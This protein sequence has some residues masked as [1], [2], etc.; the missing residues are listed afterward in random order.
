MRPAEAAVLYQVVDLGTVAG[1]FRSEARGI[2][3]QGAVWGENFHTDFPYFLWFNNTNHG[4]AKPAEVPTMALYG[5]NEARQF[6]GLG[7]RRRIRN[8]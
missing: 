6:A 3:Q 8:Q 4:V 5:M 1:A 7:P 2:T